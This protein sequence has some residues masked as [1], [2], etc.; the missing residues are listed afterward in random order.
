MSDLHEIG[1]NLVLLRNEQGFTQEEVAFRSKLSVSRLQDIEYGCRNTTV[2]TLIRIAET[3]GVDARVLGI[4]SRT[5]KAILLEARQPIQL[6]KRNGGMLQVCENIV[7]LRKAE[8]MT[9]AQLASR[10]HVSPAC[11]R[12][13]EHGC[14]NMTVRKLMCIASAFGLSLTELATLAMPEDELLRIVRNA[15][16]TAGLRLP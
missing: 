4:F 15:K 2:D 12:D 11:L 16:S 1:K 14:T 9:Q 5:E 13:I 6:P 8:G 7:L 3:L 10:S